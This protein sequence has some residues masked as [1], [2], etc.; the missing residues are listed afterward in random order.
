MD[1]NSKCL[2]T[3]KLLWTQA[4]QEKDV[5]ASNTRIFSGSIQWVNS[6]GSAISTT[7]EANDAQVAVGTVSC[8]VI[9]A[10]GPLAVLPGAIVTDTTIMTGG[11]S[12]SSGIAIVGEKLPFYA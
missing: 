7:V 12:V 5:T 3:N 6:I 4:Y 2:A 1:D 9:D 8:S 10:G 11:S